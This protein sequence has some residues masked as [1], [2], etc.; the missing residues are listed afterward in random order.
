MILVIDRNRCFLERK[1]RDLRPG[2]G[3]E[4]V[5][6]THFFFFH[7][8]FL[9]F[10]QLL[11]FSS[12]KFDEKFDFT[13]ERSK[14]RREGERKRERENRATI[15]FPEIISIGNFREGYSWSYAF[16]AG[17]DVFDPY[18]SIARNEWKFSWNLS[19]G[20]GQTCYLSL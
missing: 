9:L 2:T 8:L 1:S 11:E 19:V 10:F 14:M 15:S 12:K 6:V 13:R 17:S 18:K 4:H 5:K 7:F 16:S 20:S 3:N